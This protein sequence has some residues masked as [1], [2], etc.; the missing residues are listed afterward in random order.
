MTG[1]KDLTLFN[2]TFI[3]LSTIGRIKNA[4]TGMSGRGLELRSRLLSTTGL[5]EKMAYEVD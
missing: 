5:G 4:Q 1:V 2:L 3:G